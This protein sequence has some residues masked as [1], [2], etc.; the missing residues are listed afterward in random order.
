MLF[1]TIS[2]YS[3]DDLPMVLGRSAGTGAWFPLLIVTA[4]IAFATAI[5]L[6]LGDKFQGKT[7]FEYSQI[8][9][10]KKLTYGF[11]AFY[12]IYFIAIAS[13][14][15]R[16]GA[17]IIKLELLPLTPIWATTLIMILATSYATGKGLANIGR[18]YEFFGYTLIL[19]IVFFAI[20]MYVSGD[21]R[22][23]FPLF[24]PAEIKAYLK[25]I[26]VI[27]L[28]FLGSEVL[29]VV[30]LCHENGKKAVGSGIAAIFSVFAFYLLVVYMSYMMMGVQTTTH[31][32]DSLFYA[33]R[34]LD[35]D[36]FQFLKRFDIM[37]FSVWITLIF[38]TLSMVNYAANHY[39]QKM[40]IKAKHKMLL[41]CLSLVI[42][43]IAQIP[44]SYQ[45]ASA[46]F[47][48]IAKYTGLIAVFLIPLILWIVSKVKKCPEVA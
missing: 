47:A 25:T 20:L 29:T 32:K 28:P 17:E 6:S 33:I 21:V 45:M 46:M 44:T 39:F 12:A 1:I 3:V 31:Y 19:T 26:L 34:L 11:A 18:I 40:I 16:T 41:I 9:V 8:L 22:N 24:D 10:G 23:I 42:Y 38:V 37:A 43:V 5:I 35:L 14:M 30:P 7:L 4:F 48:L 15:L 2:G 13:M 27:I 36:I